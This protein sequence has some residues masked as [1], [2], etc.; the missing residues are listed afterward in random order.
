MSCGEG[1][2]GMGFGAGTGVSPGLSFTRY[3][4]ETCR[5]EQAGCQGLGTWKTAR[6]TGEPKGCK[7]TLEHEKA[8]LWF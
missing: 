5:N 2:G 4:P 1:T 6:L 7:N 3:G 8:G